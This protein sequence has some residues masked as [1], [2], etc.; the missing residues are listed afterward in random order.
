MNIKIRIIISILMALIGAI[1]TFLLTENISHYNNIISLLAMPAI[2]LF[3]ATLSITSLLNI[4]NESSKKK[5]LII[6]GIVMLTNSYLQ[7]GQN[8]SILAILG[9]SYVSA[10]VVA[11]IIRFFTFIKELY[12]RLPD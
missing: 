3:L 7:F 6:V 10:G 8:K 12:N 2:A 11:F 5:Y 4:E 1:T 9:F